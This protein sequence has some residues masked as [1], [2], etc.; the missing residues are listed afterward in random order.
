[1]NEEIESLAAA[2]SSLSPRSNL[3]RDRLMFEAGRGDALRG[4]AEKRKSVRFWQ[5]A[6][7][8]STVFS[9]VAAGVLGMLLIPATE[10]IRTNEKPEVVVNGVVENS[11]SRTKGR[12]IQ[13]EVSDASSFASGSAVSGDPSYF[14]KRNLVLAFGVEKLPSRQIES[15]GE[16]EASVPYREL[17]NSMDELM[18]VG[19]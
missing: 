6:A 3:N 7:G 4:L 13:E 15:R 19:G 16:S 2:L 5:F 1:M 10:P 12:N 8:F 18:S 11:R 14:K 17:L 9:T